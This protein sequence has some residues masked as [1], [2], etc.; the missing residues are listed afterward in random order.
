MNIVWLKMKLLPAD[1]FLLLL[2]APPELCTRCMSSWRMEM[3]ASAPADAVREGAS[4]GT[5]AGSPV[6]GRGRTA[7]GIVL[8]I[9]QETHAAPR[10][11]QAYYRRPIST[12][13]S[14]YRAAPTA[15]RIPN[16]TPYSLIRPNHESFFGAPRARGGTL[17]TLRGQE[18]VHAAGGGVTARG[19]SA[20]SVSGRRWYVI[21][22]KQSIFR[23][24]TFAHMIYY[25]ACTTGARVHIGFLLHQ[26]LPISEFQ[27]V[28]FSLPRTTGGSLPVGDV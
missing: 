26:T 19:G 5:D 15:Q 17:R 10:A 16:L 24:L 9:L 7:P 27:P 21:H 13:R 14:E 25:L 22:C 1:C 23:R 18:Q 28:Y 3:R 2:S 12:P 11:A 4:A 8:A 6:L 20:P